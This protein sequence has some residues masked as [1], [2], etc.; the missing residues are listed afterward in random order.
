VGSLVAAVAI[1]F[2]IPTRTSSFLLIIILLLP[3]GI[4]SSGKAEENL[5]RDSPRI[6]IDEIIGMMVAFFA[7]PHSLITL[8]AAFILFRLFDILKLPPLRKLQRLKGGWGI[9]ADDLAAGVL[10]N[11]LLRLLRLG[12]S[13]G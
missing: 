13:R 8:L 9:M 12:L 1:W 2:L 5:G 10:A 3:L 6:V 4:W 11:L 7:F